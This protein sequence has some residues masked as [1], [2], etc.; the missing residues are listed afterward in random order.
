[1]LNKRPCFYGVMP[2][3]CM[4]LFA[5]L[6]SALASNAEIRLEAVIEKNVLR[7][8][9]QTQLQVKV[10]SDGEPINQEPSIPSIEGLSFS[11][12]GRQIFQSSRWINGRSFAEIQL[13]FNYE[14]LATQEGKFTIADIKVNTNSGEIKAPPIE[15]TVF[16]GAEPIPTRAPSS[17][18]ANQANIYLLT[19]VNKEEVYVGEELLLTYDMLCHNNFRNWF[20][21]AIVGKRDYAVFEEKKGALKDFL[22]ESIVMKFDKRLEPVRIKG[23][24][25]L[26]YQNS[27][28]RYIL[29]PLTPGQYELSPLIVQFLIRTYT[30]I[31]KIPIEP[32]PVTITVKPLPEENKP[33]IFEGAVGAFTLKS[34]ADPLELVEGNTVNLKITLK[35]F[36]NLKNA[37]SPKLPDLSKFAQFDPTKNEQVQVTADGVGGQ[38]EYSYVLIPEDIHANTIGPIQFAYFDPN[39]EKYIT[40]R[41]EPIHLN[42]LP[43]NT[44]G[45][46]NTG[47]SVRRF[48]R[49]LGDDFR[50]NYTS[51]LALSN[52]TL[53]LY[54]RTGFWLYAL[55]PFGAILASLF[56]KFRNDYFAVNPEAAKSKNAPKL[57]KRLLSN[58]RQAIQ[59]G[60]PHAVYTQ[61]SK[62]ITDYITNRWNFACAG[63]TLTEMQQALSNHGVSQECIDSVIQTLDEFDGARFSGAKLDKA[64]VEEDYHKAEQVLNQLMKQKLS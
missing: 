41:T 47:M 27:L 26:Y 63:M 39:Q 51:P 52:V 46:R 54:T 28:I 23:Q 12:Q 19:D 22:S 61:L 30:N 29:F 53:P 59:N 38:I 24:N 37:P 2:P 45:V 8:G 7:V 62:A 33:E 3:R 34:E 57:A 13:V 4:A 17:K 48:I 36:G 31:Q 60:D 35:G 43:S 14:V 18:R 64:K 1:M 44:M 15:I 16:P 49:R 11:S 6:I 56:V 40:L 32:D 55:L 25:D 10:I 20:D 50:F 9:D 5:L 42:I 58:A 21:S